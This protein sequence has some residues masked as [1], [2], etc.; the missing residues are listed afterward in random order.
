MDI[1]I[2]FMIPKPN[3]PKA[4]RFQPLSAPLIML[5]RLRLLMLRPIQLHN[6]LLRETNKIDHISADRRLPTKLVPM[7][8]LRPQQSPQPCLSLRHLM[9]QPPRKLTLLLI[10]IHGLGKKELIRSPPL[11]GEG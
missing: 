1:L 7:H 10:A 5:A 11:D 4:T 9:A 3:H 2:H 6:E 8:L